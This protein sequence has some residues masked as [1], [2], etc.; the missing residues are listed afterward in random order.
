MRLALCRNLGEGVMIPV[1][2]KVKGMG[3]NISFCSKLAIVFLLFLHGCS[4]RTLTPLPNQ[5]THDDPG[6][7]LLPTLLPTTLPTTLPTLA[8]KTETSKPT[9]FSTTTHSYKIPYPTMTIEQNIHPT[10]TLLPSVTSVVPAPMLENSRIV[11]AVTGDTEMGIGFIHGDDCEKTLLTGTPEHTGL[12]YN[13]TWSP[14][15]Q[16]IAFLSDFAHDQVDGPYYYKQDVYIVSADGAE[17][18][19]ITNDPKF[20]EGLTWSP[21][22]RYLVYAAGNYRD[23]RDLFMI[24]LE[25]GNSQQ[26]TFTPQSESSPAWAPDG[27][28]IAYL[29][30]PQ[31]RQAAFVM[32][33]DVNGENGRR[34]SDFEAGNST[35]AWSP[36]GEKIAFRSFDGCGDIYTIGVDGNGLVRLTNM[37]AGE[38]DPTWSPDGTYIAFVGSDFVCDQ[39]VGETDFTG[40][41]IYVMNANGMSMTRFPT[42]YPH[43]CSVYD[44]QW[45]PALLPH[46]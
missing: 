46:K 36:N 16:R 19:R 17:I 8:S 40:Q 31:E 34:L 45:S 5:P 27:S 23:Q 35:L 11:Y 1:L 6:R 24:N 12:Y 38:M 39:S 25:T 13:P 2:R 3:T 26:L 15:G 43:D 18:K 7:T 14:D 21:D 30:W 44:L 10:K 42:P 20:K 33:M 28:K 4:S 37:P 9:L 22:G 29:E 41:R 32:V